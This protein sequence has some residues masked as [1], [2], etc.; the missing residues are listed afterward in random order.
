VA[1]GLIGGLGVAPG[2]HIGASAAVFEATHGTAPL[3][4]GT[5]RANPVGVTLSAAMML[6]YIGEQDAGERLEAAVA[7]VLA[8]GTY[9]THDLRWVGDDRLPATTLQ[10]ADAIIARLSA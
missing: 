10:V 4:A 1:A 7:G 2:G 9:L 8:E 6:R 3:L 5:N